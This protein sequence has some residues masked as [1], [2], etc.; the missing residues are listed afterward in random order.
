MSSNVKRK[1][2]N[3]PPFSIPVTATSLTF[4]STV[5]T[6]SLTASVA[7]LR[8]TGAVEKARAWRKTETRSRDILVGVDEMV[9]CV[10]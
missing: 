9:D 6:V 5:L 7:D 1:D 4:R 8:T 10:V 3:S 2:R